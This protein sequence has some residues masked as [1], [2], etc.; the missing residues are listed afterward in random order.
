MAEIIWMVEVNM[1]SLNSLEFRVKRAENVLKANAVRA[2]IKA[3]GAPEKLNIANWITVAMAQSEKQAKEK[4][5]RFREMT[6]S[7]RA[8]VTTTGQSLYLKL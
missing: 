5:E 7:E 2:L 1:D 3:E 6:I 4:L 8:H